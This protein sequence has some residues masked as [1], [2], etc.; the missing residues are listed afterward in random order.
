MTDFMHSTAH[1]AGNVTTYRPFEAA[2]SWLGSDPYLVSKGEK[3]VTLSDLEGVKAELRARQQEEDV[4][5]GLVPS[6]PVLPFFAGV[7]R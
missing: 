3:G 4:R 2:A 6:A 5:L 7:A 1:V